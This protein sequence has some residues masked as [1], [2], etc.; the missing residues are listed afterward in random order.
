MLRQK[1]QNINDKFIFVCYVEC[2]IYLF[3]L[4]LVNKHVPQFFG[5]I[6]SDNSKKVIGYYFYL[7]KR[8]H[9]YKL[10]IMIR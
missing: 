3:L 7:L 6:H 4:E 1:V 10:L 5:F 9:S 2:K 8:L